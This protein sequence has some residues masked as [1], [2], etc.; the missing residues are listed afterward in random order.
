MLRLGLLRG[1]QNVVVLESKRIT[2]E[3]SPNMLDDYF[4]FF[5]QMVFEKYKRAFVTRADNAEPVLMRGL[6]NACIFKNLHT[7]VK[8]ALKRFSLIEN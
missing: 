7:Q 1:L 6:K 2:E 5:C 8:P 3:L 4:V